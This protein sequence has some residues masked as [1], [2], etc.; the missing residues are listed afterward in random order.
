MKIKKFFFLS[1][2]VIAGIAIMTT[3]C[4]EDDETFDA[5]TVTLDN[6]A[7]SV[8]AGET[9]TI[10]ATVD[11]PGGFSKLV[12]T[13]M[14]DG[15][16]LET[17][18]FTEEALSYQLTYVVVEDDVEPIL[19][20][21]FTATDDFDKTGSREAVVDV[22]LT[23]T[24]LLLKYDWLLSDEIRVKT[25]LSDIADAYTDDVYRFYENG[26]Y[27]KSIG[28]KNDGWNDLLFNYCYWNLNE[29][30]SRLII[31]K[32]GGFWSI[33]SISD[34]IM[35]TTLDHTELVGDIVYLG[36][37]AFNTGTE[38]VPYEAVEDYV[39]EFVAQPRSANFDPYGV[40]ADDDAGP[41]ATG[42][43]DVIW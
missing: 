27:D 13:R 22:E 18:E 9:I 12:V 17:V 35:I 25:G 36:L 7:L 24:Q 29:D 43:I 19:S 28:A 10:T 21:N 37:D 41:V 31:T 33:E 1:L 3:S 11:A 34:T 5:P 14:H 8:K 40:G 23:M 6:E 2:A 4:S 26:S 39:K 30:E 15:A 32:T 38:E 42:C 16:S 20:F